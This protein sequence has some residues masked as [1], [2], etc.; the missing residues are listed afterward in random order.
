MRVI[1][2]VLISVSVL[3]TIAVAQDAAKTGQSGSATTADQSGDA[4]NAD[5]S[6]GGCGGPMLVGVAVDE[7]GEE[8]N[9]ATAPE[10]GTPQEIVA[11]GAAQP[12]MP[13]QQTAPPAQAGVNNTDG[14]EASAV[15]TDN[16]CEYLPDGQLVCYQGG[17]AITGCEP[18][19]DGS[20]QCPSQ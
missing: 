17:K 1:I 2:I 11:P 5:Q 12:G 7:T 18:Q 13:Q 19:P 10:A 3:G 6:S 16:S 9:G 15:G 14:E 4:A 20:V 8:M